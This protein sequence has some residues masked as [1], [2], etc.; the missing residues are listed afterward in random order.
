[1]DRLAYRHATIGTAINDKPLTYI[2][3]GCQIRIL[4]PKTKKMWDRQRELQHGGTSGPGPTS[5]HVRL[6]TGLNKTICLLVV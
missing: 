5:Y 6:C 1:M 2:D 3:L 4:E